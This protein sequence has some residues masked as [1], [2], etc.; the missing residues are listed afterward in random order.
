MEQSKIRSP[1]E[2]N[3]VRNEIGYINLNATVNKHQKNLEL[4]KN[5]TNSAESTLMFVILLNTLLA[6]SLL[7]LNHFNSTV[8]NKEAMVNTIS[9]FNILLP[10][11]MTIPVIFNIIHSFLS[12]KEEDKKLSVTV[13]GKII[14]TATILTL[15]P[16]IS[17]LMTYIMNPQLI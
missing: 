10:F 17:I 3:R 9:H 6:L 4:V 16:F 13:I 2:I 12:D 8:F 1:L 14:G 15:V 7:T 11:F 5:G